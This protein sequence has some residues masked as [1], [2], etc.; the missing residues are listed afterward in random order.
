MKKRYFLFLCLFITNISKAQTHEELLAPVRDFFYEIEDFNDVSESDEY[1]SNAKSPEAT[2]VSKINP[3]FSKD[4]NDYFIIGTRHLRFKNK[5]IEEV[6][7][8]FIPT[9]KELLSPIKKISNIEHLSG[10][11]YDKNF[12]S[13][14]ELTVKAVFKTTYKYDCDSEFRVEDLGKKKI[15][16]LFNTNCLDKNGEVGHLKM[17]AQEI[18]IEE[19]NRDI[20]IIINNV[21]MTAKP[22]LLPE[23]I[24]RSKSQSRGKDTAAY[25]VKR[26]I[27][28]KVKILE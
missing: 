1:A 22:N 19:V 21:V 11:E 12:T 17:S 4:K 9:Q 26:L 7:K 2:P 18:H 8:L 25:I 24:L 6:E 27:G 20:D 28:K 15:L 23:S 10:D 13:R 14:I 16:K 3:E 5:T